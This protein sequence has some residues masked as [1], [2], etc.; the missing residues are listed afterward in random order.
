MNIDEIITTACEELDIN[1]YA[2]SCDN[3]IS[4]E[5]EYYC[6]NGYD[7]VFSCSGEDTAEFLHD[8]Y[9][10]YESYDVDA[11]AV[12]MFN[13]NGAP[14]LA[15]CLDDSLECESILEKLWITLH[16]KLKERHNPTWPI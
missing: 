16:G 1:A 10:L 2:E 4:Y 11:E 8:L 5:F 7:F 6:S 9:N 13:T 15:H 12:I 14:R 3:V